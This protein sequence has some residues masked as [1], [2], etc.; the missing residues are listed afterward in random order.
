[1]KPDNI[2]ITSGY[3]AKITDM[4]IALYQQGYDINYTIAPTNWKAPELHT[5]FGKGKFSN[6]VDIFSLGLLINYIF[7]GKEHE[8]TDKE[9]KFE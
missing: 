3:E 4:G 8:F 1:M 5:L 9:V 6:S 2:M 7:V